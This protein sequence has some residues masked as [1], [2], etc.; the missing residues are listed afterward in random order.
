MAKKRKRTKKLT[1]EEFVQLVKQTYGNEFE[2]L[3]EY[4]GPRNKIK[5]KHNK[6]GKIFEKRPDTIKHVTCKFCN[7]R[8]YTHLEIQQILS[9]KTNNEYVL[10]EKFE[11][12]HKKLEIKHLNCNKIF[13]TDMHHMINNGTRCPYCYGKNLKKNTDIFKKEV[14]TLEKDNYSVLGEYID[15]KTPIKI[16][17]NCEK[18]NN[19][20]FYIRP[21]D[22]TSHGNRCPICKGSKGERKISN[23]LIK[24]NIDFK[25]QYTF[26]DCINELKLKFDFYLPNYNTIIE[27]DGIQHF[28]SIDYFGGKDRFELDKKRDEIKN[29]YCNKNNI[30]LIRI[31]Y[32]EINKIDIILTEKLLSSTTIETTEDENDSGKK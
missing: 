28:K 5:I 7:T 8:K 12:M 6:C 18:C 15:C 26:N 19:L 24:N 10:M 11:T 27:F 29:N 25:T 16:R 4:T 32:Y 9:E 13:K 2:I 20:E 14:Y 23:F 30:N 21:S 1:H 22:F 17:H 31:P 3:S